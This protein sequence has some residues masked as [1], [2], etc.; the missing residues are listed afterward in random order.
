[1]HPHATYRFEVNCIIFIVQ[2][3]FIKIVI[4]HYIFL[5]DSFKKFIQK[6]TIFKFRQEKNISPRRFQTLMRAKW[7]NKIY[8]LFTDKNL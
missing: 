4:L 5:M 8:F 7:S 6:I 2:T 1:M 3:A